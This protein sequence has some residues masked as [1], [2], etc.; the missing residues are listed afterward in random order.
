[1]VKLHASVALISSI[2][3]AQSAF[4]E[5]VT[6]T[7]TPVVTTT[8]PVV[9]TTP[10]A[11]TIQATTVTTTDLDDTTSKQCELIATACTSAGFVRMGPTGKGFWLDC[12]KP[13]LMGQTVVGVTVNASDVSACRLYR[14]NKLQTELRDLQQSL[15]SPLPSTL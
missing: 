3:L 8:T 7:T 12:M 1:M 5:V 15:P 13:I 10:V 6:T 2:L 11:A 4:A 9:T 14:I